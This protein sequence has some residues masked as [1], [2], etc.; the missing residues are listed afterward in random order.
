MANSKH[1]GDLD[2]LLGDRTLDSPNNKAKAPWTLGA[3]ALVILL[4]AG[5]VLTSATLTP[6][7]AAPSSAATAAVGVSA[8]TPPPPPVLLRPAS[9]VL[10]AVEP[11]GSTAVTVPHA[12][13][14]SSW[15]HKQHRQLLALG[16]L[17]K[18]IVKAVGEGAL[19][20]VGAEATGWILNLVGLMDN[21]GEKLDDIKAQLSEQK[22]MLYD[23]QRGL[24]QLESQIAEAVEQILSAIED[25]HEKTRFLTWVATLN[26]NVGTLLGHSDSLYVWSQMEPSEEL[27]SDIKA[28][29]SSI[30]NSVP[31]AIRAIDGALMG[32]GF[33]EGMTALFAR[34][35]FKESATLDAYAESFYLMFQYY[36]SY[37]VLGLQLMVEAY[38][39]SKSPNFVGTAAYYEV[40]RGLIT[41]QTDEYMKRAPMSHL[42]ETWQA[43]PSDN[44][45]GLYRY[46][47]ITEDKAYFYNLTGYIH[48]TTRDGASLKTVYAGIGMVQGFFNTYPLFR[49]FNN[50]LYVGGCTDKNCVNGIVLQKYDKDLILVDQVTL[51]PIVGSAIQEARGFDFAD[52]R[53]YVVQSA[54]TP[55]TN[56]TIQVVELGPYRMTHNATAS[57]VLESSSFLPGDL[58]MIAPDLA[59]MGFDVTRGA[60]VVDTKTKQTL[61]LIPAPFAN[62]LTPSGLDLSVRTDSFPSERIY[63]E[64]NDAANGVSQLF[65]LRVLAYPSPWRY[66]HTWR[67]TETAGILAYTDG[68]ATKGNVTLV[69]AESTNQLR[70]TYPLEGMTAMDLANGYLYVSGEPFGTVLKYGHAY[71]FEYPEDLGNGTTRRL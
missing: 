47:Q 36:Y 56:N 64:V 68:S 11:T 62:Y 53:L 29:R 48:S 35:Q 8:T 18:T 52:N 37:E 71:P 61:A 39:A 5:T 33:A 30:L 41:A 34:I 3:A 12:E 57:V 20:K 10:E 31:G 58:K 42:I 49:I 25:A 6:W 69:N 65:V 15:V 32:T 9:R 63:L 2:S 21:T 66:P 50:A 13:T 7:V 38:H 55:D 19:G 23:I 14:T 70:F 27:D 24:K 4:V 40:W 22:T 28:L 43:D 17:T 59:V 16:K 60:W 46:L 1:H 67:F 51:P 44:T 26:N 45:I 54:M